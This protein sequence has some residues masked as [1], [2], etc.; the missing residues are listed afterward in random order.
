M[1]EMT[2]IQRHDRIAE[3][4]RSN[5]DDQVLECELNAL[6]FLLALNAPNEPRDVKS[7]WIHRYIAAQPLD[8]RE[9]LWTNSATVTTERPISMSPWLA[10][11]CSRICRTVRPLR[12]AAIITLESRIT[13]TL[14]DSTVCGS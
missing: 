10:R 4:Q 6:R 5:T 9:S 8:E 2:G 1:V 7:H 11:T 3:M 14:A 12:S 13:P